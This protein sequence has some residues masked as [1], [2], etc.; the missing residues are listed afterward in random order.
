MRLYKCKECG[1]V[2]EMIYTSKEPCLN[3]F[4]EIFPN[5]SEGATE[6]HLPVVHADGSVIKVRVASQPHPMEEKHWITSIFV[7]YNNHVLR[8]DLSPNDIPEAQFDLGNYHG[9]VQVFEYCNLH[10]LW[11]T[12]ITI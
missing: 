1:S 11:K 12:G 9:D 6:K 4:E 10:G 5:S 7:V 8:K 3:R 2:M